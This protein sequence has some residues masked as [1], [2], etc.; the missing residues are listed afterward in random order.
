MSADAPPEGFA[1]LPRISPFVAAM[2]PFYVKAA[3]EAK[4]LGVRVQEK[5]LNTRALVQG[6]FLCSLADMAL[7]YSIAYRE[8]PPMPLLTANLS[9]D[10]AGS[11]RLDDWL[12]AHVDIQRVGGKLAFGNAYIWCR[13]ERIVR[14]S[15]V[16]AR[17]PAPA[18]P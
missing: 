4:V 1:L 5:H 7:G 15:A 9:V 13:G 6:G 10:F 16:F 2:G 18:A 17:G 14:A 8:A 3:G 12:E 11:A